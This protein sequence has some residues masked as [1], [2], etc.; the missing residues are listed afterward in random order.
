MY[1]FVRLQTKHLYLQKLLLLSELDSKT[2]YT[3]GDDDDD[4]DDDD[5][6]KTATRQLCSFNAMS[7]VNQMNEGLINDGS[8]SNKAVPRIV[9]NDLTASW[10]QVGY[11]HSMD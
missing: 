2:A 9:V 11:P 3:D 8:L 10:S 1:F 6:R 5:D 7:V 4:D